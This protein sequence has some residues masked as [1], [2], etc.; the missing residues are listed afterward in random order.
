LPFPFLVSA[1]ILVFALI[2]SVVVVDMFFPFV[3]GVIQRVTVIQYVLSD[4]LWLL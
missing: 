1:A 3:L 2:V 4:V